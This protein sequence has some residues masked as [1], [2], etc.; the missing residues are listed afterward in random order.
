MIHIYHETNVFLKRRTYTRTPSRNSM[1]RTTR[2]VLR[3][4]ENDI[5]ERDGRTMLPFLRKTGHSFV[6]DAWLEKGYIGNWRY[7]SEAKTK[8]YVSKEKKS[9]FIQ[10]A[11]KTLFCSFVHSL[12]LQCDRHKSVADYL[13]DIVSIMYLSHTF[14]MILTY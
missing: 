9:H 12:F 4:G 1:K 2:G 6:F 13:I 10:G 8:K 14:P 5:S 7:C 3:T 11:F